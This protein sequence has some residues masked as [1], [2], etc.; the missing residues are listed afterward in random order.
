MVLPQVFDVTKFR[1]LTDSCRPGF[2]SILIVLPLRAQG[3][4]VAANGGREVRASEPLHIGV[5]AFRR[6]EPDR[7][8]G[9]LE[10]AVPIIVDVK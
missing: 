4:S 10:G 9:V 7:H 2:A 6:Q 8:S 5:L 3:F 1:I